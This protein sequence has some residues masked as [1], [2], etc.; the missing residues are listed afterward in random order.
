M[1][2]RSSKVAEYKGK[3]AIFVEGKPMSPFFYALTDQPPGNKTWE[4]IPH[5]A[6][7]D[8]AAI[9]TKLF[10][11]DVSMENVYFR[12][13]LDLTF[14]LKQLRGVREAC[15][16]CCVMFRLHVNPPRWWIEEHP[17]ELVAF[18]D[19]ET[20]KNRYLGAHESFLSD[21]LK[22]VSRVSF[23]SDV[24]REE[25]K[26]VV[27]RF[28]K[29]LGE[30][31][32][33]RSLVAIQI[34]NGIYGENHYWAS[35]HHMPDVGAA[36]TAHFRKWLKNKYGTV[37]NLR[38]CYGD[39]AVDFDLLSPAG[40]ER[41]EA[42][43]GI[44]RDPS[45]HRAVCDYFECQHK[46]TAD[47]IVDFAKIVKDASDGKLLAGA[48][49]GYY[50]SLFGKAAAG[51]HLSEETVLNSEY[52]DFMCAP[53]AYGKL[54]REIGGPAM[55]RG[56]IES[57]R[58]HGK[59]WL[60]ERDQPS[61]YGTQDPG[62]I[63]YQKPESIYNNRAHT[64]QSFIRGAGMWFYDFG[65]LNCAGWWDDPECMKENGEIKKLTDAMFEREY[66]SPADV[67]LVFDT[68]VFL[69]TVATPAKDPFTDTIAN[70]FAVNAYRSGAAVDCL[71]LSD[72][73]K[74]DLSRYRA[75]VFVNCFMLDG[76]TFDYIQNTVKK[77]CANVVF[78]T[79]PAYTDG[80]RLAPERVSEICSMN[81]EETDMQLVPKIVWKGV[82]GTNGDFDISELYLHK[83]SYSFGT[84]PMFSV[85][86]PE[87]EALGEYEDGTAA[88]AVKR[89]G[90]CRV[91][92][93]A[94]PPLDPAQ[95]SGLFSEC[96][97]HIFRKPG[98]ATLCGN[99]VVEISAREPEEGILTLKNGK[100]VPY[101]LER[102]ETA[103]FDAE[104]GEKFR[105]TY[106]YV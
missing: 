50:F 98:C 81:M 53:Q 83:K 6:I 25:Y 27:T 58:L 23:A 48:F 43:D 103:V 41:D 66:A 5:K 69:H 75:V 42:D 18:A 95:I 67:L 7:S 70:V 99:G 12:T 14:A 31:E 47:N 85:S 80:K 17:S 9:G 61:H 3:P 21:D 100:R 72:I 65:K 2:Y 32:E 26:G 4:T 94:V 46:L 37:E 28:I 29:E 62:M 16:D 93:F 57:V 76:E 71:Y 13:G 60:D 101:S 84:A 90:N 96:G 104:T 74:A 33:S 64:L 1:N 91:W 59:L 54:S 20:L 56:I 82:F 36:M 45:A 63:A 86:D 19:A 51:G 11:C 102:S 24:W 78:F 8:F 88:A 92:F 97:C 79:Y 52:I 22:N 87:A 89:E 68:K 106:K 55:S 39:A 38:R 77:K 40:K 34:A 15:P 73:G 10:Q 44:F 35:M 105:F 30:Y 49:Y